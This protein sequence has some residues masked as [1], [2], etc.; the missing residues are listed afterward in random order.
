M[1]ISY[2]YSL[3]IYIYIMLTFFIVRPSA[4][5][6]ARTHFVK[7]SKP[8]STGQVIPSRPVNVNRMGPQ[9]PGFQGYNNTLGMPDGRSVCHSVDTQ[10]P[11]FVSLIPDPRDMAVNA[12][13]I[14]WNHLRAY[15]YPPQAI[16]PFI[17]SK[18]S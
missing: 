16:L 1:Y 8:L 14:S 5:S 17:L 10:C 18:L 12:L 6:S 13:S 4:Q 2:C 15:V 9:P 7:F 11:L 3:I